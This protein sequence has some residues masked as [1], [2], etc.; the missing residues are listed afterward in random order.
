MSENAAS[1]SVLS[2]ALARLWRRRAWILAGVVAAVAIT[3]AATLLVPPVYTAHADILIEN[4][5]RTTVATEREVLRSRGLALAVVADMKLMDDPSFNS[6]VQSGGIEHDK[7]YKGVAVHAAAQADGPAGVMDRALGTV[8]ERFLARLRVTSAPGAGVLRISYDD[9]DPARAALIANRIA[10]LYLDRRLAAQMDAQAQVTQWS[11]ARIE[12]LR[13]TLATAEEKLLSFRREHK[14]PDDV[15]PA[16]PAPMIE[17]LRTAPN[18][19]ALLAE[20]RAHDAALRT[21]VANLSRRYGEKHPKMVAAR[22]AL[23]ESQKRLRAAGEPVAPLP[24]AKEKTP[25]PAL[26]PAARERLAVLMRDAH[27]ARQMFDGFLAAQNTAVQPPLPSAGARLISPAVIPD[28]PSWPP[29]RLWLMMAAA[30]SFGVLCLLALLL[31]QGR[32]TFRTAQDIESHT[33]LPC[34]AL[35]PMVAGAGATDGTP[36]AD[37]VLSPAARHAAES[38]RS[39]RAMTSLRAPDGAERPRV[40]TITSSYPGEGKST[41]AAWLARTAAQSGERVIIVDCDMRR[42]ALHRTFGVVRGKSLPDYLQGDARLEDIVHTG[43]AGG[44]HMIFAAAVPDR[45]LELLSGERLHRLVAALRKTYDLV[46]LD[47]PACMAVTDPLLLARQ[48]DLTLYNVIW[49]ETPRT[50]LDTALR[51]FAARDR[52]RLALVINKVDMHGYV[53]YGYGEAPLDYIPTAAAA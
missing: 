27:A 39:L 32:R 53:A 21:K 42:P 38:L 44:V 30:G 26:D 22:A 40:I 47:A 20:Y 5:G 17:T 24:P 18:H 49:N 10:A 4:T 6:A 1:S 14:L 19:A 46:I 41:L 15:V 36:L 43:D 23:A 2:V 13:A 52:D 50:V 45:A 25:A 37:A 3:G 8:T 12:T 48:A 35:V 34:Y 29:L 28:V 31:G 11:A 33:G 16:T 9:R 7:G 51:L